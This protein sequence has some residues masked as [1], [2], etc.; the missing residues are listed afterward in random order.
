MERAN[1]HTLPLQWG[2]LRTGVLRSLADLSFCEP[3]RICSSVLSVA[4]PLR[5]GSHGVEV[6]R[7]VPESTRVREYGPRL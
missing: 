6:N 5:S 4:P 1:A 7:V 2:R 3:N